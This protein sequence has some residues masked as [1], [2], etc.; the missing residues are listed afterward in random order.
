MNIC[1]FSFLCKIQTW[2]LSN[3]I[4]SQ[5]MIKTQEIAAVMKCSLPLFQ[6]AVSVTC[7]ER[8]TVFF[9]HWNWKVPLKYSEEQITIHTMCRLIV[10]VART[11]DESIHLFSTPPMRM[12]PS[13]KEKK[14]NLKIRLEFFNLPVMTSMGTRSLIW[15][16]MATRE[17]VYP[18]P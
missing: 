17:D 15:V 5:V 2:A 6:V 11:S 12:L 1:I 7:W 3:F 13:Y 4:F 16:F 18:I 9:F 14:V 8:L 10:P